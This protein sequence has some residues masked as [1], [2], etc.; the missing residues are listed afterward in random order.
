M[1]LI[2]FKTRLLAP[3][4]TEIPPEIRDKWVNGAKK[5]VSKTYKG[6]KKA[7]KTQKDFKE[8]IGDPTMN[9]IASFINPEW[10]SKHGLTYKDIMNKTNDS[11]AG[12]G[13][14]YFKSRQTLYES[15]KYEEKL[16]YGQ[17]EYARK[18]CKY[19]GPLKGY[20][21]GNILG[22]STMAIMALTGGSKLV[23]YLRA[24]NVPLE[25][26][27]MVITTL[28]KLN[29]F[30]RRLDSRIV[31]WGSEIITQDY[32]EDVIMRANEEINQLVNEYR[33]PEIAPFSPAGD[34]FRNNRNTAVTAIANSVATSHIDFTVISTPDSTKPN[35]IR[36]SLALDIQ[37]AG[38]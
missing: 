30:R 36:K 37:V 21:A 11:L 10:T 19:L 16:E 4:F 28:E 38:G 13:K 33:R 27:P 5:A 23:D 2:E 17:R 15:G 22:L 9:T 25:G 3:Y 14:R 31:H 24:R 7:V 35:G 20:K 1:G 34:S 8:K 12:A 26:E 29:K 18:W 6:L 32:K